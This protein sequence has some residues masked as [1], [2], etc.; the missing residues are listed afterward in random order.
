MCLALRGSATLGLGR[1]LSALSSRV[2]TVAETLA[3]VERTEDL[4]PSQEK[5]GWV[6][7]AV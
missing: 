7:T 2:E 3:V 5:I 4:P 1:A 6:M